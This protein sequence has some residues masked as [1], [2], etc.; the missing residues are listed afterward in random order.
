MESGRPTKYTTYAG[1]KFRT[2]ETIKPLLGGKAIFL[3][4]CGKEFPCSVSEVR[5]GKRTSCG[6]RSIFKDGYECGSRAKKRHDVNEM[7]L[8]KI[9][10]CAFNKVWVIDNKFTWRR[11]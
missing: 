3:C 1:E 10:K 11:Q 9:E 6:C 2:L 7:N 8:T 4:R 5:R